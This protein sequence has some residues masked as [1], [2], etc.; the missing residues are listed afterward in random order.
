MFFWW[1]A[2]INRLRSE[3]FAGFDDGLCVYC[4]PFVAFLLLSIRYVYSVAGFRIYK[5]GLVSSVVDVG[6]VCWL[7]KTACCCASIFVCSLMGRTRDSLCR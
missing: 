6:E 5:T 2:F 1:C 3:V 7:V 4:F